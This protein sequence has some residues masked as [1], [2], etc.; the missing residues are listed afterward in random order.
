MEKHDNAELSGVHILVS[1]GGL[2]EDGTQ[3]RARNGA[4]EP[5]STARR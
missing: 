4:P 1:E 3:W 2:R 5:G